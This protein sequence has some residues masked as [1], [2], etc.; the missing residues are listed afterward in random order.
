LYHS[1]LENELPVKEGC[2]ES[3]DT[4]MV[5]AEHLLEKEKK[6]MIK[7][8]CNFEEKTKKLIHVIQGANKEGVDVCR[9]GKPLE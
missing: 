1:G 4:V 6:A 5:D 2:V 7:H 3:R 9:R 8:D